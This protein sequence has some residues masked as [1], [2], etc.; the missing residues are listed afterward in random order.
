M[1][2]LVRL[3]G[4]RVCIYPGD[5]LPAHF[6]V[7]GPGWAVM[8][9]IVSLRVLKGNGSKVAIEEAIA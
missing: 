8:V 6:H 3:S 9:E 1:P 2:E 5:H 7:R 4:C